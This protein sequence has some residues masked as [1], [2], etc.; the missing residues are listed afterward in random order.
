[1]R[2]HD[3]DLNMTVISRTVILAKLK[4]VMESMVQIK[5]EVLEIDVPDKPD[6]AP[7]IEL[8]YSQLADDIG[9]ALDISGKSN[10]KIDQDQSD[11]VV[12]KSIPRLQDFPDIKTRRL[13]QRISNKNRANVN[14]LQ[15]TH[16]L[17]SGA[18]LYSLLS[19]KHLK[20]APGDHQN[21][22]SMNNIRVSCDSPEGQ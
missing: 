11:E 3:K 14:I 18:S 17:P 1:M 2:A 15:N 22:V 4:Y 9:K 21:N 8:S 6:G 13:S 20:G 10:S 5:N 7:K 16:I 12:D 19:A